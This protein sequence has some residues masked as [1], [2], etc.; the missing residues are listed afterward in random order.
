MLIGETCCGFNLNN[1]KGMDCKKREKERS[2]TCLTSPW[3]I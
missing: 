2:D 1:G 3:N